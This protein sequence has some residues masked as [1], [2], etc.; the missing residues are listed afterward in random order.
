M[1]T[2]LLLAALALDELGVCAPAS[3]D[4]KPVIRKILIINMNFFIIVRFCLIKDTCLTPYDDYC[5]MLYDNFFVESLVVT[6]G[7]QNVN[8]IRKLIDRDFHSSF[9]MICF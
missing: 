8:A 5:L 7:F 3:I 4:T 1:V 9:R 6:L 2:F